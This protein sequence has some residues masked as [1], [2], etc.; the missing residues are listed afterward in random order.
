M[1]INEQIQPLPE[2]AVLTLGLRPLRVSFKPLL[3]PLSL[4]DLVNEGE[5]NLQ[6]T[7]EEKLKSTAAPRP[8]AAA[9]ATA[10]PTN[11]PLLSF[12]S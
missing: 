11:L 4:A 5:I 1:T 10:H 2:E 6:W 9:K 7:V 12:V 3:K 8:T